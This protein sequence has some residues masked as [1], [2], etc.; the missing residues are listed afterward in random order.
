MSQL[1]FINIGANPISDVSPLAGIT[2]LRSLNAGN[3]SITDVSVIGTM[4]WLTQLQLGGNLISNFSP[5]ANLTGLFGF[6]LSATGMTDSDLTVINGMT[7]LEQVFL[8]DNSLMD[9]TPL[10]NKT[11]L[12]RADL[13][14]NL[15]LADIQPLLSNSGIGVGDEIWLNNTPADCVQVANLESTGATVYSDCGPLVLQATDLCSDYAADDIA[16]FVDANLDAAVRA[17]LGITI[18][19]DLTCGLVT[20][21]TLL[22]APSA[23][24]TTLTGAQ[25]LSGLNILN[26]NFNSV[27]DLAPIATLTGLHTLWLHQNGNVSNLTPVSGLTG[28]LSLDLAGNS[29]TNIGPLS[30][31]TQL[32]FINIGLNSVTDLSPLAGITSLRTLNAGS[33]GI[34]DVTV[35]GTMTWLTQLALGGNLIADFSPL[36]SLTNLIGY[37]MGATG[38]TNADLAVISGM[39]NLQHTF[40]NDNSL[41]D[42]THLQDKAQIVRIDLRGNPSLSNIAPLIANAGIGSGDDIFLNGTAVDCFADV[43][44]LVATGATVWSDC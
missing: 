22:D 10:Q 21:M 42:L 29:I 24:I 3:T 33:I 8:G 15:S 6:Y 30:T 38:M 2:A 26:L 44:A 5:L 18:S 31:L 27:T 43:P 28:M 20:G 25:N 16:T 7:G 36:A 23:G 32:D 34:T 37:Y 4:T 9:L 35:V 11:L 1:D 39:T 19:D 17:E 14:G 13:R 41:T 12:Q 40:L